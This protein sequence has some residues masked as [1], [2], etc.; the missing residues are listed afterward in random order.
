[1]RTP[2]RL[3]VPEMADAVSAEVL[4]ILRAAEVGS[5]LPTPRDRI[6]RCAKLVE[7]GALD[8][9]QFE[10]SRS[11]RL[12]GAFYKAFGKL[13]GFMDRRSR[14][15]YVDPELHEARR[16]FVT[17][18]EVVHRILPWQHIGYTE[19]DAGTIRDGMVLDKRCEAIFECEANYG[20]AEI[21]FQ[22]DR[23]EREARDYSVSV[24]S[25]LYLAERYGASCHSSLR[26]FAERNIRPCLLL[27][28][29]PTSRVYADGSRSFHISHAIASPKFAQGFEEPFEI[30]FIN[31]D[32]DLGRVL[33]GSGEGEINLIDDRGFS[34]AC[35]VET[36]SNKYRN[37]V[38][39]YP[40]SIARRGRRV[41][42]RA[43]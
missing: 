17:Y 33:N 4:K 26:R 39:I 6:V 34:R 38:L 2:P 30:P 35:S 22:G 13:L 40:R 1:M 31:P 9:D 3:A 43:S 20:A 42:V 29:N 18:H 10:A 14:E 27:V 23:F 41:I 28:T 37:F 5:E 19:D 24:G 8:L 7:C 15:V 12:S 16:I 25:A 21:I 32:N 11:E 36:F